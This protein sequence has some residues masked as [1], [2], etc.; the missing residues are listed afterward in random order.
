MFSPFPGIVY[1]AYDSLYLRANRYTHSPASAPTKSLIR[2]MVWA[3]PRPARHCPRKGVVAKPGAAARPASLQEAVGPKKQV[4][5]R[6]WHS[7][8]LP[9]PP[10]SLSLLTAHT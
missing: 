4:E 1:R 6:A 9:P 10:P 7:P 8:P 3:P 2:R 5:R